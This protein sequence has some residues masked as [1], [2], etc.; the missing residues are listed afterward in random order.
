[1]TNAFRERIRYDANACG[2]DVES[3]SLRYPIETLPGGV[4]HIG[5]RA[6]GRPVAATISFDDAAFDTRTHRDASRN[7]S[8]PGGSRTAS[9]G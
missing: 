6:S 5:V 9:R 8:R 7:D 1:M 3:R 4:L 2:G